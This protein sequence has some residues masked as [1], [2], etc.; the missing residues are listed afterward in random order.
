ML[1]GSFA[2]FCEWLHDKLIERLNTPKGGAAIVVHL[3]SGYSVEK[4][5]SKNAAKLKDLCD[6][7]VS[8]PAWVAKDGKTYCSRATDYICQGFGHFFAHDSLAN[9]MI[10]SMENSPS[11]RLETDLDRVAGLAM[12]GV[13][14]VLGLKEDPHGHVCVVYPALDQMSGTWG[15][16]VPLVA[17]VGQKNGVLKLSQVFKEAARNSIQ[18]FVLKESEA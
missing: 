12:G 4:E 16:P 5:R 18:V 9:G 1:N 3:G 7:V 14:V 6:F 15:S 11:W 10:I 8:N 2:A 17:N 13:L